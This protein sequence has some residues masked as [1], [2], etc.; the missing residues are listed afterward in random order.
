MNKKLKGAF[1]ASII[2]NVLLVGML[3]GA[4]RH[5]FEGGSRQ[6][7]FMA[8]VEKL[9][10]PARSRLRDNMAKLRD[11]SDPMREQIRTAR[12]EAIRLLV[13]EPFEEIAYDR[14]ISKINELR[15][16]ITTRM[17]NEMKEMIKGL[18]P[19]QRTAVGNILRRPPPSSR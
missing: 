18:P 15:V 1:I 9:P 16:Q 4:L 6:D 14:Q 19:E 17:S 5:R 12:N 11:N 10:E 3:F 2:L 7:R 13:A 8:E